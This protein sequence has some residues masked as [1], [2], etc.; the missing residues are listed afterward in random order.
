MK[1]QF[2]QPIYYFYEVEA[3]S[4]QEA[5]DKTSELKEDSFYDEIVG[6]WEECTPREDIK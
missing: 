5:Y 4:L 1:F 3:D 2:V 6:D